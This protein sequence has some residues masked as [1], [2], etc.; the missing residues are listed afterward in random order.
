MLK[1]ILPFLVLIFLAGVTAYADEDDLNALDYLPEDNFTSGWEAT[2]N[3]MLL[4]PEETV[5]I[6][7]DAAFLA[8]EFDLV[9][10]ATETYSNF[11]DE[12]TIEIFEFPTTGDAYGFYSLSPVPYIEP[13]QETGIVVEPY[14][15]PP[16][17]KIDTIRV[18]EN[19]FLEGYKDR[20]YFRVHQEEV[21]DSLLQVG[22]HMLANLPGYA[23][24]SEMIG[25]LPANE[26]VMGSERYIRGMVGLD[27]LMQWH[28]EDYLGFEEYDVRAVGAEYRLG[29]GEY[30]LYVM[31][32]YED[33]ETA[34]GALLDLVE[35]FEY[36]NWDTVILPP[37]DS[38][39]HP[40]GY[41]NE[42]FAAF[43][44]NDNFIHL[45]WDVTDVSHLRTAVGQHD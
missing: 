37:M 7:D 22:L 43:W 1:K 19:E 23:T 8:M 17:P 42:K 45:V 2:G 34:E 40:R 15:L 9:W 35:Y 6:L 38:G 32:E 14:G 13:D 18:V 33:T 27:L 5:Y 16:A 41:S 39:P 36:W 4:H 30:Y 29:S 20:F 28:G 44:Q 3:E 26:R 25:I 24:P 21:P 31:A 10:Y 11:V 12:L